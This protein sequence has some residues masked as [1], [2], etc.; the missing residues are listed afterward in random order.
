MDWLLVGIILSAFFLLGLSRL[1]ICIRVVAIQGALLSLLPILAKGSLAEVPLVLMTLG[2]FAIKAVAMPFLLF[3]SLREAA[4]R[5]EV[6]PIISLHL[7]LLAGGGIAILAFSSLKAL[8]KAIPPFSPI[9]VPVALTVV[10][11]GFLLLISRRKAVTQVIG[12][13]VLENGVFL[14]GMSL[15]AGFPLIVEMGILLDLLVGIFVMGIMMYHIHRTFD[16]IDIQPHS[17]D[18]VGAPAAL[19]LHESERVTR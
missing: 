2:T 9:A 16:H 5:R 17:S 15:V 4:I 19:P 14:F 6:E 18:S 3:R 7:S 13:L 12:F 11:I 8:P 10:L 1:T